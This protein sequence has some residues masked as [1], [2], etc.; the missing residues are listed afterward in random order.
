MSILQED[1]TVLKPYARNNRTLK[2]KR[3]KLMELSWEIDSFTGIDFS[4]LS[5]CGG[6]IHQAENRKDI[7]ELNSTINQLDL[8][9]VYG[10]LHPTTTDY[11]FFSNSHVTFTKIDHT[12]A[13]KYASVGRLGGSVG[14]VSLLI[15]AQ[16]M[17]SGFVKSSPVLGSCWQCITCLEFSLP[18]SL[19]LPFYLSQ[20]K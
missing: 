15:S 11:T 13:I 3:Q 17:I 5:L 16:I 10:L 6:Q 18:L 4:S 9:D 14:W 12:W 20:N 7:S 2:Y 19:T 8:I 1:I